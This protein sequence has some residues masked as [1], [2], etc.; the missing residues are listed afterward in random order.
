MHMKKIYLCIF[1]GVFPVDLNI[2]SQIFS[3]TNLVNIKMLEN[4]PD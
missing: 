4:K 3:N 1:S 2:F